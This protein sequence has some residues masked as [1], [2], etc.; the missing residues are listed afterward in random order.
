[1]LSVIFMTPY[2]L[3]MFQLLYDVP[4]KNVFTDRLIDTAIGSAIAF[5]ANFLLVPVWEHEQ[6]SGYMIKAI[7]TNIAYFK[8]VAA[9]F[10]GEQVLV[11]DYKI[12]RKDAFVALA[13]LSDALTRMLNEPKRVQKNS[14]LVHQFVV[15]NHQ[16]T[17]HIAT[18]SYYAQE[19][20]ARSTTKE[21]MPVIE[22]IVATLL[23]IESILKGETAD[24]SANPAP[25]WQ[26][27]DKRV[28][29]LMEKRRKELKEGLTD[30]DTRISLQASK[31]VTDQFKVIYDLVTDIKKVSAQLAL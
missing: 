10:T 25:Y 20:A 8:K 1:M 11:T 24:A 13:N 31:S 7:E 18:L 6:I 3:V 23:S 22:H 9:A 4:V 30:T 28:T 16:L 19:F 5:I 14:S 27:I 2:V 17:S 15:Y 12:S 26:T 29:V 21:F